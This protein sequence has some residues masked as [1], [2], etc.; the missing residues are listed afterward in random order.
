VRSG[1]LRRSTGAEVLPLWKNARHCIGLQGNAVL[2]N[3]WSL[4]VMVERKTNLFSG[5]C[6]STACGALSPLVSCTVLLFHLE[7]IFIWPS[8]VSR[9]SLVTSL[10][11]PC[12]PQICGLSAK[13]ILCFRWRL[14][15][16]GKQLLLVSADGCET[17]CRCG[18]LSMSLRNISIRS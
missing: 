18:P 5:A 13:L 2:Q 15:E 16:E 8:P 14:L 7:L 4:E 12:P 6:A 1:N 11:G 17:H 10:R 3:V 9:L